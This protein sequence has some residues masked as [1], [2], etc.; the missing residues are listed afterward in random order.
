MIS[1]FRAEIGRNWPKIHD[2]RQKWLPKVHYLQLNPLSVVVKVSAVSPL[3]LL[4]IFHLPWTA[5]TLFWAIIGHKIMIFV[6]ITALTLAIMGLR[7]SGKCLERT[8]GIL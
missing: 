6:K 5:V 4:A 7:Q 8:L 1:P 2:F 3:Y